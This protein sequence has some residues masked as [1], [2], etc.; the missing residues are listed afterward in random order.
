MRTGNV[1]IGSTKYSKPTFRKGQK[2]KID[3]LYGGGTGKIVD[4]LYRDVAVIVK[5]DDGYEGIYSHR[6]LKKV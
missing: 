4:I 2:V 6:V 5:Q 3:K 1:L